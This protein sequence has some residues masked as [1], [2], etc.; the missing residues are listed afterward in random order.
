MSNDIAIGTVNLP[1]PGVVSRKPPHLIILSK[2]KIEQ[3]FVSL[4]KPE[5]LNAFIVCKGFYTDKNSVDS[6]EIN[7]LINDTSKEKIEELMLPIHRVLEIKNLYFK[8][9]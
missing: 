3:L 9:K 6:I 2:G 1:N 7:K 8:A 5:I 4:D